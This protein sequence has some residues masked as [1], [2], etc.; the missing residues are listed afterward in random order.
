M[1]THIE[2]K[3]SRSCV[4]VSCILNLQICFS[5]LLNFNAFYVLHCYVEFAVK[6]HALMF[7]FSVMYLN[8]LNCTEFHIFP[9][10]RI[11]VSN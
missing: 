9:F 10:S 7:Q 5:P 4:S 8:K 6:S 2:K 1:Q 11:V 3:K